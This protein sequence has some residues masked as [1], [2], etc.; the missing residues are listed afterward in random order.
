MIVA[1]SSFIVEGVLVDGNLL[2]QETMVAPDLV[3][4]ETVGAIWKHEAL[5]GRISDGTGFLSVLSDLIKSN[6]LLALRPDEELIGDAYAMAVRYHVH[7]HDAIFVAL[8]VATGL[9]LETLDASQRALYEKEIA[10]RRSS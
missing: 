7:P 5:L 3:V 6:R 1:D 9:E 10:R 8:A 4:Y 2:R